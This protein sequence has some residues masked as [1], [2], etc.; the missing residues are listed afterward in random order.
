MIDAFTRALYTSE[1]KRIAGLT[2]PFRIQA[3]LDEV[4]YSGEERYRC[5]LSFLRDRTGHCFDGAVF[6]AAMLQRLGHRP[7]IVDMLPNDR[8]D[9]H[10]LA[11]YRRGGRW[12]AVAKSNFSGLRFREPVYR[13]LRELVM[14]YFEG[15]FNSAGEKT[16]R[17]YTTP[18]NLSALEKHN[19]LTDD[20]AMDRI[21]ERL[22]EIRKFKVLTP[23][24]VKTLSP[25]DRRSYEAGMLGVNEDGLYKPPE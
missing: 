17:A 12:G 19:W 21:A 2:T 3:F 18:L 24:M 14:S 20:A 6:A 5:P 8:D 11:L 16:L 23:G 7:L 4:P 22:D 13:S 10:M 9:D 15:Y 1:R 25:M